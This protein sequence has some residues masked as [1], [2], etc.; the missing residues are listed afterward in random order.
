VFLG[1]RHGLEVV[2][3]EAPYGHTYSPLTLAKNFG[4]ESL[5]RAWAWL[6]V[7]VFDSASA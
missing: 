7:F 6:D 5:A 4:R 1:R 3:V 2:G